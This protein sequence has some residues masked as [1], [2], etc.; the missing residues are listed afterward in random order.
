M[1]TMDDFKSYVKHFARGNQFD[2]LLDI[3]NS[4]LYNILPKASGDTYRVRRIFGK[5]ISI[6][7]IHGD[8]KPNFFFDKKHN[9]PTMIDV[10]NI[11]ITF[12][13]TKTAF[14]HRFFTSWI[15]SRYHSTGALQ[16]Y[17]DEFSG[18]IRVYLHDKN[19]YLL[20]GI[21]PVAVS[22]LRLDNEMTDQFST[23]DVT[24]FV[25]RM[26]PIKNLGFSS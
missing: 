18:A 5:S 20:E 25:K 22:D 14:F 16:F 13:D 12:Y 3:P 24:F 4:K 10:D 23:F 9:T 26:L 7:S 6:P 1:T 19:V 8:V 15:K 2:F 11:I 21:F 17:P